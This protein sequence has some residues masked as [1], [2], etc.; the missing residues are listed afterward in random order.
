M[1]P[2]AEQLSCW[3]AQPSSPSCPPIP[4]CPLCLVRLV[5]PVLSRPS[6]PAYTVPPILSRPY[7]S[8]RTFLSVSLRLLNSLHGCCAALPTNELCSWLL[9]S[10][11][12]YR[13]LAQSSHGCRA[14]LLAVLPA[15]TSSPPL[16]STHG[17]ARTPYNCRAFPRIR[18]CVGGAVFRAIFQVRLVRLGR[19]QT[20][21][22][23]SHL[24]SRLPAKGWTGE[25]D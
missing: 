4:F 10:T 9:S 1:L 21:H 16:S 23:Q 11:F 13:R 19:T 2:V 14:I 5:P 20:V 18:W 7:C 6:C 17:Q 25:S 3:P 12:C 8:V 22:R 24:S 15:T